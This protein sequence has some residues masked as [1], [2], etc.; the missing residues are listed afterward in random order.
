MCLLSCFF[1]F[2]RPRCAAM[3]VFLQALLAISSASATKNYYIDE[4][5]D[6]ASGNCCCDSLSTD[7]ASFASSLNS[8]GWGGSRYTGVSAWPQ[9]FQDQNAVSGGLDHYWADAV[10]LSVFSGHG[11]KNTLAY[12][13]AR[14]GSCNVTPSSQMRLGTL[15]GN[16]SG[17][18][19]LYACCVMNRDTRR[20]LSAAQ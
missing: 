5:G 16:A 20:Q 9:D 7:T 3:L 2:F 8:T 12:S 18:T 4:P 13:W 10:L 6:H 19:I 15:A 1:A 17:Y 11:N 14:S